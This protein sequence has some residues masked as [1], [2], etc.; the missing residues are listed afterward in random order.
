MTELDEIR[1]FLATD[2]DDLRRLRAMQRDAQKRAALERETEEELNAIDFKSFFDRLRAMATAPTPERG[3]D[4]AERRAHRY[5]RLHAAGFRA[6]PEDMA[7]VVNAEAPPVVER[8]PGSIAGFGAVSRYLTREGG[9][10]TLLLAGKTGTGKSIMAAYVIANAP[11]WMLP[12]GSDAYWL[13]AHH[14]NGTD[15]HWD[16]LLARAA[17]TRLLV[18]NEISRDAPPLGTQRIRDLLMERAERRAFTV[19]TGNIVPSLAD[20]E[21]AIAAGKIT[22]AAVATAQAQT[23]QAKF[24]D[25]MWDRLTGRGGHHVYCGGDSLRQ[26]EVKP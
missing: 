14:A 19:I 22:G 17:G 20:T 18:L 1:G 9:I 3:P 23:F 10:R 12:E 6:D 24:G 2:T 16:G 13:Q 11:G 7:I 15:R 26:R 8:H 21:K 25:A 5:R 4:L